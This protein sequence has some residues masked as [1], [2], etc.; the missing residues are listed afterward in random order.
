MDTPSAAAPGFKAALV[1]GLAAA[2]LDFAAACINSGNGPIKIGQAIATGILGP[3]AFKGGTP[4]AILGAASHTGILLV[5]AGIYVLAARRMDYLWRQPLVCGLIFGVIVYSIMNSVVVPF[6]NTIMGSPPD[7]KRLIQIGIH[8][9][10]VGLPIALA[11][12][13]I[14]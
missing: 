2:V 5:V 3:A 13:K 4:A 8:M 14:R 12:W 1:G 11:A 10:F 9:A 6:S 7:I